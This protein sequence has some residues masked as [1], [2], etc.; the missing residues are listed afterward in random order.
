MPRDHDFL[1]QTHLHS[2]QTFFDT[3]VRH[4]TDAQDNPLD[5]SFGSWSEEKSTSHAEDA[6]VPEVET[7]T[8]I[9]TSTEAPYTSIQNTQLFLFGHMFSHFIRKRCQ[10][11]T[12]SG[13]TLNSRVVRL[14]DMIFTNA[15]EGSVFLFFD[16][17]QPQTDTSLPYQHVMQT[18]Y[19][20]F[21]LVSAIKR[22]ELNVA[23]SFSMDVFVAVKPYKHQITQ[24]V[25]STLSRL[26][27]DVLQFQ[28]QWVSDHPLHQESRSKRDRNGQMVEDLKMYL[29]DHIHYDLS[30]FRV[31]RQRVGCANE[32]FELD[33]VALRHNLQLLVTLRP[34]MQTKDRSRMMTLTEDS[35]KKY[36][37]VHW[38]FKY[39]SILG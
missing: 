25:Y 36:E 23:A 11:T 16:F 8:V 26:R 10:Q 3:E 6:V 33:E 4:G 22:H 35:L 1:P 32:A 18:H 39:R 24:S 20:K 31:L 17:A 28:S 9:E 12:S 15:P 27:S 30:S 21:M 2:L 19:S 29:R 5:A 7:E 34:L 13:L 38:F 37:L 14:L